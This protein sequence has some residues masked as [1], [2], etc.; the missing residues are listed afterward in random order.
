MG[1]EIKSS[2]EFTEILK[3]EKLVFADFYAD[4][5]P[6]CKKMDPLVKEIEPKHPSIIFVKINV[7][8]NQELS[9]EYEVQAIPT[10]IIFQGSKIMGREIGFLGREKLDRFL[11]E[12][13]PE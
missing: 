11:R 13:A 5:C 6:P 10:F 7:D 3:G 2:Q 1:I 4:W 9:M 12:V 8:N